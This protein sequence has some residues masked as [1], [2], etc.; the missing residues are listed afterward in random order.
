MHQRLT[1]FDLRAWWLKWQIPYDR[2]ALFSGTL[3]TCVETG[4]ALPASLEHARRALNGT[5]LANPIQDVADD[6]RRGESLADALTTHCH[7]LPPF[8]IPVI[9]AGERTGRLDESL[10]FLE[11]HCRVLERPTKAVR[12]LWLVPL[13]V[14]L[15]GTILRFLVLLLG[16]SWSGLLAFL[17][18]SLTS[19]AMLGAMLFILFSAPFRP[20]I[21]FLKLHVPFVGALERDLNASRFFHALEMLHAAAGH[22]V[23]QMIRVATRT[24]NNQ[25]LQADLEEVATHIERGSTIAEAFDETSYLTPQQKQM[26]T[27]GE[28]SGTLEH[29]YR[30]IANEAAEKLEVRLALVQF[31]SVRIMIVFVSLSVMRSVI[32]TL[33][34]LIMLTLFRM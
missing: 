33:Y 2:L 32:Q 22:R 18:G 31:W 29:S 23:E 1:Q 8:Y 19:Y 4:L 7:S 12:N 3:A 26:I 17:W 6:V 13:A 20:L 11:A 5:G 15:A 14:I 10:R 21:D 30:L 24:V 34:E 16:G 28:M 25:L 27:T 9:E